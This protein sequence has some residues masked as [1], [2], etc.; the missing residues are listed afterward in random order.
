[1]TAQEL[2]NSILQL[3]I[4]GKLVKQDQ[5]DEPASV[6][7]K[8]I[9][10]EREKLIKEKKIKKEKYSEIYKDSSDNHYYEKFEDGTIN[11]ITNEIPFDIPDSWCWTRLN[12]ITK[13]ITGFSFKSTELKENNEIRVIRISDFDENGLKNNKIVRI[14]SNEKFKNYTIN[15]NSIIMAMTG[16]TV[17][18]SY[19]IKELV[20]KL[21]LNQR[22]VCINTFNEL[23]N[24]NYIY[25]V[26]QSP[27]IKNLIN[28]SKNSTNDNISIG[29]INNF[30]IPLP[31][32]NVQNKIINKLQSI[33][34]IIFNYNLKYT[35]LENLNI[36]YK[37]ELKKSIL[38]YAIQGKL[39]KQNIN[40]ESAEVLI[41][42]ILDEKRELIKTKQ[43]KKEN[44]SVIYKDDT[45]NQFYEKF[46]DGRIVNITDEIPF[47]IPNNW[48]WTRLENLTTKQ[49]KR[50]KS[51][52]YVEKSNIYVF[53]QKCNPKNGIITLENAKFLDE[54]TLKK[55]DKSDYI[56]ES[57]IVINSTGN[58]TLGRVG[59]IKNE[60]IFSK[61]VVP[62]SHVTL[63]RI[64]NSVE[65][66][67]IFYFL[68][69]NQ[70]YLEL[71]ATGSTNQ[72]ELSPEII[73]KILIPLPNT[74]E[75]LKIIER[76]EILLN[77]IKTAE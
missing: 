44:L 71:Q 72:T 42:K 26:I 24:I 10:E 76:I 34:P 15:K 20:E 77:K 45:D 28:T 54:T 69:Y 13:I 19:L 6:L 18:K 5:N 63:I 40:D 17:G 32:I 65:A 53:A 46:D 14:N 22:V 47:D 41:N 4:Q 37:E 2:K 56:V 74:S 39:I 8:K 66:D 50:G 62:D 68:K 3:A 49:I 9:K 29:I 12:N 27:F 73:K 33:Y 30:L 55:Y 70:K 23:I 64:I 38:Q 52:K 16:G 48:A 25:T 11:D 35:L 51:P 58:G 57:D 21:Y 61:K 31:S 59:I 7:L 43:I 67:Y 75:Q 60:D 36:S 1:M